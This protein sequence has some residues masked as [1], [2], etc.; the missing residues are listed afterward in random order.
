MTDNLYV[1]RDW[2]HAHKYVRDMSLMLLQETRDDFLLATGE[3][4][5][6]PTFVDWAFAEVGI[7][8]E[9]KG[10]SVKEKGFCTDTGECLIEI[11]PYYFRLTESKRKLGCEHKTSVRQFARDGRDGPD[12]GA[13]EAGE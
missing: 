10:E 4:P 1:Q 13:G 6:V 11:G 5:C 9:R 3:T 2:R 12:H 7:T 8:P